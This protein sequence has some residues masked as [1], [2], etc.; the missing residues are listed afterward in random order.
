VDP[1]RDDTVLVDL[2][3]QIPRRRIGL[4]RHRDRYQ[5]PAAKAFIELTRDMAVSFAEQMGE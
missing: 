1:S 5:T 2:D 3:D 4:V